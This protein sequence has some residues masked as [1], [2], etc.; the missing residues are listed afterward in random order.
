MPTLV[1]DP[2]METKETPLPRSLITT[3]F[4]KKN[5]FNLLST[6]GEV[7]AVRMKSFLMNFT[8]RMI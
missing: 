3:A 8:I 5:L 6:H 2:Q 1:T 4:G 7:I